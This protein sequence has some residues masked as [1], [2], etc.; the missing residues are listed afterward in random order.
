M[1]PSIDYNNMIKP[2]NNSNNT[3]NTNNTNNN[4]IKERTINLTSIINNV[5]GIFTYLFTVDNSNNNDKDII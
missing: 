3:N 2:I 4:D 1:P 5:I